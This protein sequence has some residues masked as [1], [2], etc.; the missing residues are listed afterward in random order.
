MS[1]PSS[2]PQ[3][4][5]VH[6]VRPPLESRPVP[7]WR[8]LKR[9]YPTEAAADEAL[10]EIWARPR[11]DSAPMEAHVYKCLRHNGKTVWHLTSQD[12]EGRTA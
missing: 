5:P 7:Q 12:Q 2:M 4:R 10:T 9:G 6:P 11:G 3:R 8:C 1:S